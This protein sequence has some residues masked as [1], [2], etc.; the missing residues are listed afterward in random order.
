MDR[1]VQFAVE[2]MKKLNNMLGIDI[3]LLMVYH[4]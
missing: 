2:M 4:P 1:G 3:K